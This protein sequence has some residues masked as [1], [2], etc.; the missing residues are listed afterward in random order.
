M[1]G[2]RGLFRAVAAALL[3]TF[4]V[5]PGMARGAEDLQLPPLKRTTLPN[6]LRVVAAEYHKLPLIELTLLIGA[7]AA[8]DPPGKE[9]LA[10]FVADA[11]RRGTEERGAQEFAEAVEFLGADVDTGAGYETTVVTAEFLAKDVGAG[12][13]LVAEMVL[14]P[15]FQK[16]ELKRE[17]AEVLAALQA[18]YESPSAIANLCYPAFLY[19]EHPYGRP[20]DGQPDTVE[21]ISR[22]DVRRFYDRYYRANN[23]IAVIVGD[24]PAPELLAQIRTAFGDW[25]PG[26]PAPAPP[27]DPPAARARRILLV[28]KPG[29]T[30]A[31]IR[32]GNV[33]ISRRDPA[34][35]VA[36]VANT[37]FGGG[38]SSRLIEE[39]RIKRSLTYSA[40][41]SFVARRAPGD[42]RIATFTKVGTTAETIRTALV[43]VDRYRNEPPTETELTKARSYLRGQFPRGLEAPDALAGRLAEIEW[44]GL[45]L[46]ELTAFRSRVASVRA[47]QVRAFVERAVPRSQTMVVVIV[48]PAAEIVPTLEGLGP[49]EITTPE[50]CQERGSESPT[51]T[52]E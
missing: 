49:V 26:E 30:Q 35:M 32:I 39:L 8:Q 47:P 10:T 1:K 13:G 18:R 29:A 33:A 50:K 15:A 27:P 6:G 28:D 46:E 52:V 38:F 4:A 20:V 25:Q 45:G 24:L 37:V 22:K 11:I 51:Q 17:R 31:Q 23:A 16:G 3:T 41:S 21:D 12:L 42:L 44:Y 43:E 34:Y 9:G 36:T 48:G 40:S 2:E 5:A 7:G 19:G 14:R